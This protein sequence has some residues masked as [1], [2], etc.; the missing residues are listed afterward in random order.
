M[1]RFASAYWYVEQVGDKYAYT[2]AA[3]TDSTASFSV[4]NILCA[5][6]F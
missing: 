2:K 1:S 3:Q 5:F 4:N 6:E